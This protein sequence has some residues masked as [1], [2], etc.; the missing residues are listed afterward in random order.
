[1]IGVNCRDYLELIDEYILGSLQGN[2][3]QELEEHL[4]SCR[5]CKR[6]LEDARA[7]HEALKSQPEPVDDAEWGAIENRA[8]SRLRSEIA[9]PARE[10]VSS[11]L[12]NFF[13][14]IPKPQPRLVFALA[15]T[16][17]VAFAVLLSVFWFRSAEQQLASG[18]S[19]LHWFSS[20]TTGE[21]PRQA[22]DQITSLMMGVDRILAEQNDEDIYESDAD[23]A[24]D[25]IAQE[26]DLGEIDF[27]AIDSQIH[28]YYDT[29]T[30][31]GGYYSDILD[32]SNDE[33]VSAIQA[34]F[35][36]SENGS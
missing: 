23:S 1:V 15:S 10:S 12:A 8:L 22:N 18:D 28:R 25:A 21:A 5:E 20:W 14:P 3:R 30:V 32:A 34:V 13:R 7:L 24:L 36:G 9:K 19:L 2:R 31:N 17:V 16:F 27:D 29:W 6:E 35:G 33:M 4:Q 11:R 26:S